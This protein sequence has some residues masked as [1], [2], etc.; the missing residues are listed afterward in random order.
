MGAGASGIGRESRFACAACHTLFNR[1][2]NSRRINRGSS[3]I[4]K[5]AGFCG[6]GEASGTPDIQN[7]RTTGTRGISI[8]GSAVFGND[9]LLFR[10]Q[11][12]FIKIVA[13]LNI[14]EC[15]RL[16]SRFGRTL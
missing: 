3:Y 4:G 11:R 16:A 9:I 14:R 7:R 13:F 12:G 2:I 15:V 5:A 1:P 8:E 10:P 6:S